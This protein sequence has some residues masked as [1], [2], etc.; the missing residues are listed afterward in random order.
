MD[1]NATILL[2]F[3][4]YEAQSRHLAKLLNVPFRLVE[5]HHFPDG[6]SRVRLPLHRAEHVIFC[7]SLDHPND[8][9]VEL[10]L[11]AAAAREMQVKKLTLVAP[12]LCYMRQDAA[13]HPGEAIS[14]RVIGTHLATLFD[15][16]ITVDPH[17]HRTHRFAEAVPSASAVALS[18]AP[19]IAGFLGKLLDGALLLGP[20]QE[21]EQ[22][23]RAIAEPNGLEYAIAVKQRH[24]DRQVSVCLP[25]TPMSGR[26]VVLVD[27]IA[28]TGNT[29][30]AA[31]RQ[32]LSRGAAEVCA[33]VTH[34]LFVDHAMECLYE[35][36][37][38]QIWSTDSVNHASNRIP[39]AGVLAEQFNNQS[40]AIV[41]EI[42]RVTGNSK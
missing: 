13:F 22:W 28:S 7:R 29:L 42:L 34:A 9:L 24:S 8:K 18:A 36:G 30:A 32:A 33:V 31:A 41:N 39:L 4:D 23:V 5:I 26:R 14:Q 19:A 20:D 40:A 25:D 35:A 16:V 10:F 21:S 27:D 6:E 12:Y 2:G 37:I 11:A 15:E 3:S 17:L 38:R 1:S